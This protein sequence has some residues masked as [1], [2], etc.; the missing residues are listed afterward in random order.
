MGAGGNTKAAHLVARLLRFGFR[1]CERFSFHVSDPFDKLFRDIERLAVGEKLA[2]II[3]WF[4]CNELSGICES[5]VW[6]FGFW[7]SEIA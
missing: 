1:R 4:G 6:A 7:E 3:R 5:G 2:F